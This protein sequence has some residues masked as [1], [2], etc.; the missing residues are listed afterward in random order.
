MLEQDSR[1]A[2][3]LV[4]NIPTEG[5][6]SLMYEVADV[7]VWANLGLHLVEKLKGAIALQSYRLE[8]GDEHQQSA[9]KHLVNSLGF[10]D[11]VIAITRPIYKDMPLTPYVNN[12]NILFHWEHIRPEVARDIEIARNATFESQQ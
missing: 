5:N 10:W 8:G 3:R 4:E 12:D 2:L 7:K 9:I 11:E 1:E 6:A